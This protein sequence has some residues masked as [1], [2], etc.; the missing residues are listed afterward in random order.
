MLKL[1]SKEAFYKE[2][3]VDQVVAMIKL[4]NIPEK[5]IPLYFKKAAFT[6]GK[7]V[8]VLGINKE[9]HFLKILKL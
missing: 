7:Q 5:Q 6:L 1:F 4:R 8:E 2:K 3:E 9:T